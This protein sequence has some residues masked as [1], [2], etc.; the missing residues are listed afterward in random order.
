MGALYW[1]LN[2]CWPVASWSSVDSNGRY[3]ALH[4]EAKRF[5]EPVHISCVETGEYTKRK[6]I[7]MERAYGY[8]TRAQIF[9]NNDTLQDVEGVVEWQLCDS[10]GNV[11]QSGSEQLCVKALSYAS[12]AE[13]DF[14]KT[15]TRDNYLAFSFKVN[16]EVVSAGTVLFTKAKHFHFVDPK[17]TL[18]VGDGYIDVTADAFAKYVYISN[19]NDDLVL[20]DNF[21][22]MGKGTKRVKIVSGEAT[23]LKVK[24]VFDIK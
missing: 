2:D 4:Y 23:N 5:Y 6:D 1:Q 7:T 20:S 12:L 16:G 21:F 10:L 17:I 3:K 9:V 14:H 18:T 8:E 11:L 19:D 22:D 24:S 15:A 13:M